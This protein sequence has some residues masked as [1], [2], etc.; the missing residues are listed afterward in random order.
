MAGALALY[1]DAQPSA[2][3]Q[4]SPKKEPVEQ[5]GGPKKSDAV[6]KVATKAVPEKPGPDGK[7]VVT[8]TFAIEK[9]WHLYAN[10][11]GVEDLLP[12]QTQVAVA[13]KTKPEEVKVE[14]PEGKVIQ[15]PVFGKYRI[16]ENK[17][18]IKAMVRRAPGANEPLEVILKFQACN[19][20]QCLL[21]VTK[22]VRV[23]FSGARNPVSRRPASGGRQPPGHSM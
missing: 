6:V 12:V 20:K 14:Y 8:V 11:P 1:L 13:S 9:G 5:T 19:D 7:Q 23:P 17:L 3:E 4:G 16:Y 18:T 10:P 15:D 22:T 21:P 2:G